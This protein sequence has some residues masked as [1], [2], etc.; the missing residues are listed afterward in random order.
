MK[1]TPPTCDDPTTAHDEVGP[2]PFI[3]PFVFRYRLE[4][5]G[6]RWLLTSRHMQ[7]VSTGR[8]ID[9]LFPWEVWA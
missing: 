8:W 9:D 7:D 1:P 6:G 3:P 2:A 5:V 4:H